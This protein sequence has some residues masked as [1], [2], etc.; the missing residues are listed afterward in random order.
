M[1]EIDQHEP[2]EVAR[3]L[4]PVVEIEIKPLNEVGWADYRWTGEAL[5]DSPLGVYHHERKLWQDLVGGLDEVEDLLRRQH[6]S[7]PEAKHRLIIE[8]GGI[9]PAPRGVLV[10]YRPQGK[11][12]M[13]SKLMGNQAGLYKR[14]MGWIAEVQRYIEIYQS[15]SIAATA[16]LL[17]ELYQHD[18]KPEEDRTTFRRHSKRINW[19]PNPQVARLLGMTLNDV[20]WGVVTCEEL[21]KDR[22]TVWNITSA[23]PQTL[24]LTRGVSVNSAR[25]FLRKIGRGDV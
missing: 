1:I 21:I 18:Q 7:H 8:G 17:H 13:L 14:I 15:V 16:T 12:M 10:Y 9:E 2:L 6:Q 23:S 20:G 19:N 11:S 4:E 24:A 5:A 3:F 25:E 22:G